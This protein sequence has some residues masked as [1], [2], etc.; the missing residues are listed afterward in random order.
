MI[1]VFHNSGRDAVD[2]LFSSLAGEE[3]AI[4]WDL[5]SYPPGTPITITVEYRDASR[6]ALDTESVT[7]TRPATASPADGR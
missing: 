1:G 5:S 2:N 4:L 6:T 7:T 3:P